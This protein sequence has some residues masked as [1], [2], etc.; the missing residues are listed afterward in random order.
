MGHDQAKILIVEHGPPTPRNILLTVA[1]QGGAYAGWQI[2]PR[3]PTV[4]GHIHEQ[5]KIMTGHDVR[6]RSAGRTDAGVHAQGQVANFRTTSDIPIRGFLRGLNTLLPHDI[7]ILAAKEVPLAFDARCHNRGKHYR[8][9]IYNQRASSPRHVLNSWHIHRPLDLQAM[10]RA[11]EHLCGCHHF[12][13]F[14][15][16]RCQRENTRR[17]LYRVSVADDGPLVYIDVVGSAFLRNMVRVIAGTLVGV[18]RGRM[19]PDAVAQILAGQ[20]RRKAGVT[21]PPHGLTLLQ[22]YVCDPPVRGEERS[23]IIEQ[24]REENSHG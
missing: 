7:S 2:Q 18:G 6:L 9:T 14:R 10:A 24:E 4:Q 19:D 17:T 3:D 1:Y 22:V 23:A 16:A 8:Y 11:G 20:D 13:A 5:L 12:D 15:S 21:A